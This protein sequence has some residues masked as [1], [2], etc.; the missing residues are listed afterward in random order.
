MSSA[1][2]ILCDNRVDRYLVAEANQGEI[3]LYHGKSSPRCCSHVRENISTGQFE[4]IFEFAAMVV[5]G[6]NLLCSNR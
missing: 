4:L 3:T 6:I 5:C 2:R 1:V